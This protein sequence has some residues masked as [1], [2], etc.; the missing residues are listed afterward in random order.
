M[1]CYQRHLGWLFEAVE[2]PYDKP[3]RRDVHEAI[4]RL[5][6]LPNEAHCP[7]VWAA[8]KAKYGIDTHTLSHELVVDLSEELG[9][10]S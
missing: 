2:Q 3:H 4:V 9:Q 5:L 7:E 8:L 1:T 6:A 10:V